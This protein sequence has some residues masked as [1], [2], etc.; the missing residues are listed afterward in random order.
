MK[1][2]TI[3]DSQRG[4]LYRWVKQNTNVNDHLTFDIKADLWHEA[5]NEILEILQPEP[6]VTFERGERVLMRDH[7]SHIWIGSIYGYKE[8]LFHYTING[9]HFN[10]CR[11]WDES[12]VGKL[13]E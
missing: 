12:L 8:G 1:G 6:P 5:V 10:Q 3:T 13:T 2:F 7:D 4:R 11:K 9:S